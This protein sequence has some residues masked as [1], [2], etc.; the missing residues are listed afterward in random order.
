MNGK[1]LYGYKELPGVVEAARVLTGSVRAHKG[2]SS[3]GNLQL[4]AVEPHEF[5]KV[6]WY[7]NDLFPVHFYEYLRLLAE[8]REGALVSIGFY[9]YHELEP[10]DVLTLDFNG[11][12]IE[13]Y[14]VGVVAYWPTLNPYTRQFVIANLGHIQDNSMLVPYDVWYKLDSRQQVQDIVTKLEAQGIYVTKVHD[15]EAQIIEMKRE[16]YRMGFFGI[17]SS[18]LPFFP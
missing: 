7:R 5:A 9:R 15:A 3:L 2:S 8:H 17:L 14:V 10:G 16:P 12:P 6:A 13:V 18:I 1:N 4:M 11:Q